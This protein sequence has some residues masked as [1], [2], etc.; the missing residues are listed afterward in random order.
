MKV[1]SKIKEEMEF[2]DLV[3]FGGKSHNQY[4]LVVTG[5]D[6]AVYIVDVV[7]SEI[8]SQFDDLKELNECE[9]YTLV[10]R[11]DNISLTY[12]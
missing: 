7:T 5:N 4:R 10:A 3:L 11:K 1:V 6:G 9:Q 2:G 12:K 8:V